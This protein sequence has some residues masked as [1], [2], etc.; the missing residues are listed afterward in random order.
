M[1]AEIDTEKFKA[2]VEELIAEREALLEILQD[3]NWNKE[4]P[5]ACWDAMERINEI[6]RILNPRYA[7]VAFWFTQQIRKRTMNVQEIK[8]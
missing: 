5:V 2:W 6:E 1:S 3:K 8:E 7:K 4:N